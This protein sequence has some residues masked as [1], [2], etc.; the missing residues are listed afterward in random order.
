MNRPAPENSFS[1]HARLFH[2]PSGGNVVDVANRPDAINLLLLE[3]PLYQFSK[4]FRHIALTPVASRQNVTKFPF[5]I[6]D[7]RDHHAD[8]L[9]VFVPL[10]DRSEERRV[11]KE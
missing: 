2:D 3:R 1:L 6:T 8:H 10:D 7:A 11:G 5:F 4:R 9:L